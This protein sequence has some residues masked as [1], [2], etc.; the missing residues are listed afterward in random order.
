MKT[1]VLLCLLVLTFSVA[2]AKPEPESFEKARRL[3]EG[4]RQSFFMFNTAHGKY[5]IRQD[6]MAEL[7][8]QKKHLFFYLRVSRGARLEQVYFHE[9]Q[10]DLLLLYEASDGRTRIGYLAR[11]NPQN[12]K[13]RW[14]TTIDPDKVGPCAVE[15]GTAACGPTDDLT[16]IDL[17][18]GA[19][20]VTPSS[21][22]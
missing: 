15:E 8:A 6:G 3:G 10:G 1:G 2:G 14:V 20:I 18:R 12:R 5:T 7:S 4:K 11:V 19:A 17:T 22:R 21:L 16:T 13:H 9:Y